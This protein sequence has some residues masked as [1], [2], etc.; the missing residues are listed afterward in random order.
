MRVG[1]L[2]D[3]GYNH[4]YYMPRNVGEANTIA[5][6]ESGCMTLKSIYIFHK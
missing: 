6:Q 2:F 5:K 1:Y 4:S 3:R